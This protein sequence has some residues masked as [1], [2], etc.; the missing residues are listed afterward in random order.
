M[1][2]FGM[3]RFLTKMCLNDWIICYLPVVYSA[4]VINDEALNVLTQ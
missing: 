1:L 3:T 4:F 2:T